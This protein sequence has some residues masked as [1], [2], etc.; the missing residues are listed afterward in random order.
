MYPTELLWNHLKEVLLAHAE[1]M[2]R[3]EN[4]EEAHNQLT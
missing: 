1:A 3:T 4:A 2:F